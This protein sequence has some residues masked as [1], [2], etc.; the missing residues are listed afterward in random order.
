MDRHKSLSDKELLEHA[1]KATKGSDRLA[2]LIGGLGGPTVN[3]LR[4]A[5]LHPPILRSSK[6]RQFFQRSARKDEEPGRV[7]ALQGKKI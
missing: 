1:I 4:M 5:M 3:D 2:E 7:R 6:T